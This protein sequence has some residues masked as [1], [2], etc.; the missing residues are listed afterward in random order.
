[1]TEEQFRSSYNVDKRNLERI[2]PLRSTCLS[3]GQCRTLKHKLPSGKGLYCCELADDEFLG[4]I[5][6]VSFYQRKL[7]HETIYVDIKNSEDGW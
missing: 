2:Q 5:G 7:P 1:M 3:K 6:G 4:K